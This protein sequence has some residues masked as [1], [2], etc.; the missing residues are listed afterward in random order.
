ML[1]TVE[2]HG[3]K[4]MIRFEDESLQPLFS[5]EFMPTDI[6]SFPDLRLYAR[7]EQAAIAI[8]SRIKDE[9]AYLHI[10]TIRPCSFE[11]SMI[12]F[13]GAPSQCNIKSKA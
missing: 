3:G 7:V 12:I 13:F 2:L 11:P 10:A 5:T 9:K 1:G 4:L 8:V 6:I